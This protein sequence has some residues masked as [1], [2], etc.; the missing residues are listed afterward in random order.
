VRAGTQALSPLDPPLTD[1]PSQR[2]AHALQGR[3]RPKASRAV[4]DSDWP[5]SILLHPATP[6]GDE[7]AVMPTPRGCRLL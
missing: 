4:P 6:H 3:V 7:Q 2:V 5:M 1:T